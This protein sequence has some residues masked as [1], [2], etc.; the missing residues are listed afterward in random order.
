M[1]LTIGYLVGS[2]ITPIIYKKFNESYKKSLLILSIGFLLW[3]LSNLFYYAD[4]ASTT[5]PT[6]DDS[7]SFIPTNGFLGN[8]YFLI[9]FTFVAGISLSSLS[10]I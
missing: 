2:V 5:D 9:F 1:A 8:Y 10:A 4:L 3:G 7:Y 6:I